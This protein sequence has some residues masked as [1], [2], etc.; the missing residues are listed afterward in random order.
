M[1]DLNDEGVGEQLEALGYIDPGAGSSVFQLILAKFFKL[2][3][4][5][6]KLFGAKESSD[7]A[8]P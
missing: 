6:G 7:E 8:G 3:L 5:I 1:N 2:K 4:A